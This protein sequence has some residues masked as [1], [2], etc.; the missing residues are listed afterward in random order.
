MSRNKVEKSKK[1]GSLGYVQ[2]RINSI[3]RRVSVSQL[4]SLSVTNL[5]PYLNR[6]F[7]STLQ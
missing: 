7:G 4:M 3:S 1:K 5:S 2:K 6:L